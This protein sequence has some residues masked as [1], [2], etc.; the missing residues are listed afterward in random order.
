M[1][2]FFRDYRSVIKSIF[3]LTLIVFASSAQSGDFADDP[4]KEMN[5]CASYPERTIIDAIT[6]MNIRHAQSSIDALD[7][8]T[9]LIDS[10]AFYSGLTAWANATRQ[11]NKSAIKTALKDLQNAVVDL[12]KRYKAESDSDHQLS[13]G[14]AAGYTAR[15]LLNNGDMIAGY[16]LGYPAVIALQNYLQQASNHKNGK[17]AASLIVGLYYIYSNSLSDQYSWTKQFIKPLGN[18]N[19]GISLIEY[20]VT[21]SQ[22]FAPEALRTLL[23]DIPWSTPG[24]CK[25]RGLSRQAIS[26]YPSS[27]DFSIAYQGIQLRCGFPELALEENRR[28][29]SSHSDSGLSGFKKENYQ[30]I[31]DLGHIRALAETGNSE[32]LTKL[33]STEIKKDSDNLKWHIKYGLANAFDIKMKRGDA[34]EHYTDLAENKNAPYS[35]QANSKLRLKFPYQS[36]EKS[37]YEAD[38]PLAACQS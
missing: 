21:H 6:G 10:S 14:L 11:Q 8:Q 1:G 4:A 28:F 3:A 34:L 27:P 2:L 37:T 5:L 9:A 16:N 35:I 15:L 7:E 24:I 23:T 33:T 17:A 26:L 25:Y 32:T 38:I 18:A 29:V 13:W 20:S 19:T 30:R 36:K 31:F 12:E 22:H